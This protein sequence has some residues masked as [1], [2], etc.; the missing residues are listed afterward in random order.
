MSDSILTSNTAALQQAANIAGQVALAGVNFA[1]SKKEQK[2]AYEY[3]RELMSLQNQYNTQA[4]EL[5]WQRNQ[6]MWQM[7]NEY[8]SPEQQVK[9]LE[10]AGLNPHLV[11]GHGS[12]AN[13]GDSAPN[14]N[15]IPSAGAGTVQPVSPPDYGAALARAVT[16]S[17]AEAQTQ[18]LGSQTAYMEANTAKTIAQT[19]GFLSDNVQKKALEQYAES[20]ARD[21]AASKELGVQTQR[22]RLQNYAAEYNIKVNTAQEILA[23]TD[24]YSERI[25]GQQ[26]KNSYDY[27][28]YKDRVSMVKQGLAHIGA[29]IYKL[30]KDGELTDASIAKLGAETENILSRGGY[31]GETGNV[32][33]L[34]NDVLSGL[35]SLIA[36]R[37]LNFLKILRGN[38]P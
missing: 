5:E 24:Y 29:Q 7:T 32:V 33:Q 31:T 6:E 1:G 10:S 35:A 36:G 11:Y 20:I 26:L 30:Y 15:A 18:Y 38:K 4:S 19:A 2:R 25:V 14:Y 16:M 37:K 34:T 17:Q 8:N 27:D 23:R 12:V 28:T 13:T 21:S 22:Q 9:R 3:N